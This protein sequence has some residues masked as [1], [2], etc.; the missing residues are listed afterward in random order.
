MV[1]LFLIGEE[2]VLGVVDGGM[3]AREVRRPMMEQQVKG[4]W[5]AAAF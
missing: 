3:D 4:S 2:G 5:R 1:T